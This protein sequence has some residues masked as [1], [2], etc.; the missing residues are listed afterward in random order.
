MDF[1][2]INLAYN[3]NTGGTQAVMDWAD[4]LLKAHPNR[5]AIVTSHW[6]ISTSFPPAQSSWG[7]HGQALYDNLKDN[8]NLFLMLCGHIHGEGRRADVFE[9][10][11]VNTVLQDYQSRSNG[12]DSWL[13]YFTFKPSEN[14]IYAYTYKT[15]TAP[16]G[17]PLGGT[18]ETDADSQFTLDYNMAATAPWVQLGTVNLAAGVTTATLPWTGLANSTTYEWYAAV[19]D[20]V[21]PVGSTTRSFTTGETPHRRSR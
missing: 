8:P 18:F 21:T 5:R 16:V 15:N 13:R 14:K 20:G 9:G 19:S 10:R 2:I 3:A 17:N 6:L 1:I 12:G 11:T 7:G 4:A